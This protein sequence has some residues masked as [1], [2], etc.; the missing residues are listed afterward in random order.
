MLQLVT[1]MS[2]SFGFRPAAARRRA[3]RCAWWCAPG[4]SSLGVS[5]YPVELPSQTAVGHGRPAL[6]LLL[7]FP[8]L[9]RAVPGCQQAA[10]RL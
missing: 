10:C 7:L 3:W 1:R 4:G 6:R 2:M 9:A 8:Q 5:L